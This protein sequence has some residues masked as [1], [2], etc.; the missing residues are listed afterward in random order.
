[1][2]PRPHTRPRF[3]EVVPW[4]PE[5]V[6]RRVRTAL[7]AAGGRVR[8]SVWKRVVQLA[9]PEDETHFWSPHLDVSLLG[10]DDGTT[11]LFGRFAP[12]PQ[13]WTGFVAAQAVCWFSCLGALVWGMSEAMLGKGTVGWWLALVFALLG[14]MVYLT[15]YV[16]Q[17][18]GQGQMFVL[19]RFLDDALSPAATSYP[20]GEPP[21]QV[22][23]TRRSPGP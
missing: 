19:R 3:E 14:G 10:Q 13:I 2:S 15:A 16:G 20:V 7:D 12:R 5:E 9:M 21:A 6:G 1:M 4:P 8:G 18:L 23:E 17:N 11:R 22:S